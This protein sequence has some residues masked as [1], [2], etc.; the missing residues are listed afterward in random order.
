MEQESEN[1]PINFYRK[2]DT[3][4]PVPAGVRVGAHKQASP[5]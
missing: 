5:R 3:P 2:M 4:H 1:A